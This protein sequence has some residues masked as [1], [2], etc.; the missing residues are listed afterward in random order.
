MP[1]VPGDKIR[2]ARFL[3]M[4][5]IAS[6]RACEQALSQGETFINGERVDTPAALV[7][8]A[9]DEVRHAGRIVRLPERRYLLLYKPRGYTCSARDAHA[10][11]L[12]TD[13][14]PKE[15][16][17]LFTV[18]RLDRESE[19]VLLVTNDGEFAERVAHPRYGVP[20]T[21]RVRCAGEI[22]RGTLAGMRRGVM[23]AGEF[24]R[25]HGV[26]LVRR[27][28]DGAVLEFV[29]TEGKKREIRRLCA[30][31]G[32]TVLRLVRKS[33]GAVAANGLSAGQWRPL[34]DAEIR[35]L[36]AGAPP[37]ATPTAGSTSYPKD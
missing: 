8:P 14:L 16:G 34:T 21:Y 4:A 32:L 13:I 11:R 18:G 7:D 35:G 15:A 17:R 30:K 28:A 20:K 10:G 22:D 36:L 9:R 2:I 26:R 19:G 3:A 6:R 31:S 29:L 37:A 33:V 27:T 12:V 23:D 25:P 1:A 5:G 24:I